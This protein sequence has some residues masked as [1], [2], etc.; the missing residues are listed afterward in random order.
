MIFYSPLALCC[1]ELDNSTINSYQTYAA[2]AFGKLPLLATLETAGSIFTAICKPPISKMSDAMGRAETYL[3]MVMCYIISYVLSA[4]AT[5]FDTYVGASVFYA[6]AQSGT[7]MLNSILVSDL[8][9]ARTRGI[10]WNLVY[11]PYFVTASVSALIVDGVINTVGWRWGI[12]MFAIFLPA[13]ATLLIVMLFILQRRASRAGVFLTKQC[14]V[15]GSIYEF[16]SR[17][18]LGGL[19]LLSGGFGLLLVPITL[20]ATTKYHWKTPWVDALIILGILGLATFYPYEKY[21]AKYPIVPMDYFR[22]APVFLGIALGH[23]DS[24]GFSATHTYLYPWSVVTHNLSPRDAQFLTN[25]N[26]IVQCVMG[27]L[28]G[29]II[30]KSRAY[31]WLSVGGA[32]IRLAGYAIM[33][34][35]RTAHSSRAQLFLVQA[36]QGIG[37]GILET[38]VVVAAQVSV[39]HT[40]LAQVTSLVLLSNFM[41]NAIG[42]AVAGAIYTGTLAERLRALLRAVSA[43][44]GKVPSTN[45]LDSLPVWGSKERTAV[46]EAV[47]YPEHANTDLVVC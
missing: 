12:G 41:G 11:M 30:Y 23:I 39:P 16:C 2:S 47:C 14:A 33:V 24:I 5:S 7:G 43:G 6:V 13:S 34:E 18:D 27:M 9:S 25:T 38:V 19:L 20:A 45:L 22:K 28:T 40:E 17:I 36:V 3:L 8:S 4:S 35:V 21:Q 1:S 31:K 26:G 15:A 29:V 44:N 46:N 10:S 37:S 32:A 42:A